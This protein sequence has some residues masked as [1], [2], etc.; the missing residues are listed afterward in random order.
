MPQAFDFPRPQTQVWTWWFARPWPMIRAGGLEEHG[1]ARLKPGVSVADAQADLQRLIPSLADAYPDVT[2]ADL[3]HAELRAMVISLKDAVVGDARPSLIILLYTVSFVLLI[4]L[5]KVANLILVRGE[6]Q[7]RE[8]AVVKA[9]GATGRDLTRRFLSES[10]AVALLGGALGLALAYVAVAWRFGFEPGQIPR[11]HEVHVGGA[12]LAVTA[13]IS[14]VSA[15]LLGGLSLMRAGRV[16]F[17]AALKGALGRMTGGRDWQ[18]AQRVLVAMQVAL[19]LTLLIASAMMVQSFWRLAHAPLGFDPHGVLTF[20]ISMDGQQTYQDEARFHARLLERLRTIPGVSGAGATFNTPLTPTALGLTGLL[21]VEN[22]PRASDKVSPSI[23]IDVVTPGYFHAM[24]IPLVR[25]RTFRPGDLLGGGRPAI[26]SAATVRALFGGQDPIGRQIRLRPSYFPPFTV[27]GVA[28][29]VPG[30]TIAGGP[31]RLV[32]FPDLDDFAA[33]PDTEVNLP[34]RGVTTIVV[35]A[36]LPPASLVPTVRR[37]V[38][39]LDPQVPVV[40]VRTMDDIV[41]ASMARARLMMLLL[42][43]A[44]GAALVL[45]VIGLY[46]VVSYTVARR[47]REIGVRIA[48]GASPVAVGRLVMRQ[49]ADV[50]VAGIGV[51]LAAAFALTRLLGSVLYD[52]SPSDPLSYGAMTGL[53]FVVALIAS[54]IPARRAGRVDPVQ[55]LRG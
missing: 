33:Q 5:A 15:L 6:R 21:D 37:V 17:T 26:V 19:A 31:S 7:H 11:L 27:V 53:L 3:R 49:S 28:G 34:Q 42:L 48:L 20:Q 54:Y 18:R 2:P 8:V 23:S 9:L 10:L 52:V 40:L 4:A 46:G 24:G 38:H 50:V 29:D 16:D 25:G 45:G 43:V 22:A 13:G 51:G 55:V 12:V 32:Y 39:D 41:A 36:S 47:R 1:I 30:E 35:R 14:I 44:G